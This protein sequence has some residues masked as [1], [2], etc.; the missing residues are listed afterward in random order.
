MLVR[1]SVKNFKTFRD[2]AV[3][4]LIAS[5]YDKSTRE[6][7]NVISIPKFNIRLLKSAVMYGASASGKTK[8]VEAMMFMQMF[9][10]ESSKDKQKDDLIGVEA[11][12]LQDASQN[13]PTEFEVTFIEN[14]EMF[15]YGFEVTRQKVVSEWLYYRPKTKEIEL[16]YRDF[17]NFS[18]IHKTNFKRGDSL[19]KDGMIRENALLLSVAAQF[20]D[21]IAGK[22][23]NWF[24]KFRG[25]SG[26][27]ERSY[28]GFT[29]GRTE[30]SVHRKRI[31]SLLNA[32]DLGIQDVFIKTLDVNRLPEEMPRDIKDFILKKVRE[33]KD[34]KFMSD[35]ITVHKIY[36][37]NYKYVG[38]AEFSMDNDESSGTQQYFYLTGPI[39]DT[40]E[41]GSILIIDEMGAKIHPNL[42]CKLISLFNSKEINAKNA[43]LIFNT[44]DTNLLKSG[45][46]RRD[47]IWF[48]Q[49]DRYGATSL[50]PLTDFE[51][52][53]DENF[54]DNYVEGRYGA[55]PYL[56]NFDAAV[57]PKLPRK[58]ENER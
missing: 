53:K 1:F 4:S 45:L 10:I 39:L 28:M 35:I 8:L 36:N 19:I 23:I 13:E 44:H 16:F 17:Q 2:E 29:I 57:K 37:K 12:R 55:I 58:Y 27:E 38:N 48:T 52:R 6:D 32:A 50:Y 46:F 30:D 54:E 43:Q 9:V 51:V 49:K 24:N 33:D 42:V 25:I 56:G 20:N 15:R 34:A 18:S 21:E 47:Q 11:F 5:N 41:E 3:L 40:L 22:V 14:N 7:E 31:L 26:I